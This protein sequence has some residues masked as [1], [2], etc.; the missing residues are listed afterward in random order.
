MWVSHVRAQTKGCELSS[1]RLVIF[2]SSALVAMAPRKRPAAAMVGD[3]TAS[4]GMPDDKRDVMKARRFREVW[5]ELP[6]EIQAE[7]KEA[8][9]CVRV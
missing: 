4:D 3:D 5:D 1:L 2:A 8:H 9:L 6:Q 7:Y